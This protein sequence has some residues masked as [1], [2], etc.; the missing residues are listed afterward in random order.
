VR[1]A[2]GGFP[3]AISNNTNGLS[4]AL[5]QVQRVNPGT[6]IPETDG[7]RDERIQ[8]GFMRL[9]Q[10]MF[11]VSFQLSAIARITQIGFLR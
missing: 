5:F 4:S 3:T 2:N 10:V 6:S 7:S 1:D 9:T 8:T 11:R